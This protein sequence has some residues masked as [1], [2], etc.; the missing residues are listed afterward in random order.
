M[1][2]EDSAPPYEP[3]TVPRQVFQHLPVAADFAD[4]HFIQRER[5]QHAHD[6]LANFPLA[7]IATLVGLI[8]TISGLIKTFAALAAASPAE[9]QAKLST[10][11][12]EAMYN[13]GFGLMIA[14][15]CIASQLWLAN[16]A[17]H[18]LEEVE[19]NSMKL[20]NLLARRLAGDLEADKAA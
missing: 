15:V 17:K 13:T 4:H 10:G 6:P 20:E 7:N 11:I 19:F 8:G 1:G 14:V 3:L 12:S 9:K 16:K 18:M 2:L 5:Q